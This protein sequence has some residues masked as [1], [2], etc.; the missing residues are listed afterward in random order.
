ME[1][2]NG[3]GTTSAAAAAAAAA[4]AWPSGAAA[5]WRAAL[6]LQGGN[7]WTFSSL[8]LCVFGCKLGQGAITTTAVCHEASVARAGT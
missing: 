4:A 2:V 7:C 5:L 8:Q 6:M 3:A 1:F